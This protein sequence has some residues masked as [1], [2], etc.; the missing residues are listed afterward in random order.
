MS[1]CGKDV[2]QD[3]G[4]SKEAEEN[5]RMGAASKGSSPRKEAKRY[6]GRDRTKMF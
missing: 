6:T 5:R 3:G 1:L 2:C 4:S